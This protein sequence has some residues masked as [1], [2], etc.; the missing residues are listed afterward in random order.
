MMRFEMPWP[1]LSEPV[2]P[3]SVLFIGNSYYNNWYLAKALRRHG[4][5]AETVTYTGEAAGMYLHGY[6]H[7]IKNET[8]RTSNSYLKRI[9]PAVVELREM[10]DDLIRQ[11]GGHDQDPHD[12]PPL[13]RESVIRLKS[14]TSEMLRFA[15]E[16]HGHLKELRPLFW[17]LDQVDVLHFT[18]VQNLRFFYFFNM[19]QFGHLPIQWDIDILRLL[20]KKIVYSNTLCL[21]GVSQ[22]ALATL[23]PHPVCSFCRHRDESTVCSDEGNLAWGRMR[24]RLVD[25]QILLGGNRA[26]YNA[27]ARVHE[28]PEFYC[29]D[30]NFWRPELTIPPEHRIPARN[31]TVKIYHAVGNFEA[32]SVGEE[33]RNIKCTHIYRP[34]I[35]RLKREGYDVELIFCSDVPN[36]EVRFYQAQADIVVDMLTFGFFGANV[37]EAMMLGK[38]AICYLR[39]EWIANMRRE[40]PEYADELPIVSATPDTIHAVLTDLIKHPRKRAEIGRRSREFAVKWH[41]AEAAG[42]RFDKIYSELCAEP[43]AHRAA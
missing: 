1:R 17:A 16:G 28:V 43:P 34:L 27:D 31:K 20:G 36:T 23:G 12:R 38:P 3:R 4:W 11:L 30:K 29:L 14:R 15:A 33:A 5:R 35:E 32:R 8:W 21:D 40:I 6:D 25:Y 39:P 42:R 19:S 13:P 18:G 2:G 7:K 41:S 22:T 9:T 26:D 37:R 24:N 10:Y